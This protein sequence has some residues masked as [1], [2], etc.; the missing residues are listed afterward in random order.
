MDT[1]N[2]KQE[3]IDTTIRMIQNKG[4]TKIS[5]NHIAKEARVSIGTLYYH[6]PN[7]KPDIIKEI[8]K[9]GYAE[10]LED[11]TFNNL[12]IEKLPDFLKKFLRSYI[13]Q[14]RENQSLIIAIEMAMLS[15]KELFEDMEY[16]QTELKLYPLI[17]SLL[18]QVGYPDKENID[19]ISK[20]FLNAID[21]LIHRYV[22]YEN[23]AESD[24]ELVAFLT[25]LILSFIREKKS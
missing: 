19:K 8:V 13:I 7:G 1:R 24:E 18:L 2:A 15:E 9:S 3:I 25:D 14:H 22:L 11:I 10:F 16:I 23:L 20:F 12:T 17:S 21:S 5:T 4:Y 6:F